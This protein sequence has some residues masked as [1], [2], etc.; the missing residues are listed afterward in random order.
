M[1]IRLFVLLLTIVAIGASA[2]E[3]TPY[4]PPDVDALNCYFHLT[5]PYYS[6]VCA[7]ESMYVEIGP[8]WH[9]YSNGGLPVWAA[10]GLNADTMLV[11]M[12]DGSYSDGIY[13]FDIGSEMFRIAEWCYKPHFLFFVE[14]TG[15]YYVGFE[16]GLLASSNVTDW[17][18][19]SFFGQKNCLAMAAY[20]HDLI[21]ATDEAIYFSADGGEIWN[22]ASLG[23]PL[24]CHLAF[25]SDGLAYGIF[26]DESYSSGLWSSVD[27]GES[28]DV[29]F[30]S[31]LMSSV[32]FDC[33]GI[34]F[35]GWES[36]D[37]DAEGVAIWTPELE[38][39][40]FLNNG[41]P[42]LCVNNLLQNHL[43]DSPSMMC[44]TRGGAFFVT[45]YLPP[46]IL[47]AKRLDPTTGRI[48]WELLF[49]AEYY[50]LYRSTVPFF[51]AEGVA[52]QTLPSWQTSYDFTCG[53]GQESVNYYFRAK[54]RNA[55]T[56]SNPSNIVGEFD[57]SLLVP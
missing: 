42:N 51:S 1:R 56:T 28:W 29:E 54:A 5:E 6:V 9:A 2:Y 48:S 26:P 40:T 21:V 57:F 33:N 52:W 31:T 15:I 8:D 13:H 17:L 38:D 16:Y 10:L 27:Y 34:P 14:S 37:R 32:A 45:G 24:L 19:L 49:S 36:A 7:S 50:D 18:D 20:G 47:E 12:G 41:L 55:T 30:W 4:G 11:I 44:C 46:M 43:I 25:D 39:L 23:S 3:W 22:E 53:I 35:V